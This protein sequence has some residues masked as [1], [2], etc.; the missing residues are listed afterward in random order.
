MLPAQYFY[1]QQQQY[2]WFP[3]PNAYGITPQ[4]TTST[5]SILYQ[6]PTEL[7]ANSCVQPQ[8]VPGGPALLHHVPVAANAAL[9]Y[10]HCY[11]NAAAPASAAVVPHPVSVSRASTQTAASGA[12]TKPKA[13]RKRKPSPLVD[14]EAG[15]ADDDDGEEEESEDDD[16]EDPTL[17]GFIVDSDEDDAEDPE[18]IKSKEEKGDIVLA[19]S[20]DMS[21]EDATGDGKDGK[22][23]LLEEGLDEKNI[24]SGKRQRKTV[25][26]YQ[27][28][29]YEKVMLLDAKEN[30]ELDGSDDEASEAGDGEGEAGVEEEDTKENAPD[31]EGEG[32]DAEGDEGEASAS[33]SEDDEGAEGE[34]EDEDYVPDGEAGGSE[35]TDAQ[36][37]TEPEA[38]E[39]ADE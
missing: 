25:Q 31:A 26:R 36:E 37:E 9:L 22:H 5:S 27:H 7:Y 18:G 21:A 12:G 3:D 34:G 30:G 23:S 17:G 10:G 29:D 28:P 16:E 35:E 14:D 39:E 13:S 1:P 38:E 6:V 2:N 33:E 4:N 11:N 32:E 15:Q 19:E 8:P 20:T 24:V